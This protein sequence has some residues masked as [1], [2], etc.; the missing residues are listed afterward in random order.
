L[1][2]SLLEDMLESPTYIISHDENH[3]YTYLQS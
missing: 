1:S 3:N 2:L